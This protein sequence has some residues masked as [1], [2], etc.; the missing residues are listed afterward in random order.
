MLAAAVGRLGARPAA[1]QFGGP[2]QAGD[3]VRR[4]GVARALRA[5]V[6]DG[7]AGFYGGEFGAGLL[8]VGAGEFVADD[9]ATPLADWVEPLSVDVFGHRLWTVPPNSQGYLTL[10]MTA[11]AEQLALPVN[12]DDPTW[13]H[14]TIEAARVASYDRLDVLHEHADGAAL[15]A[16]DRLAR[17]AALVNPDRALELSD[18]FRPGGTIHLTAVDDE[19]CGVSLIQSN[20]ALFGSLLTEPST[21]IFLQNRGLGFSLTAGHPAEYGPGRRPPHTLSPALVTTRANQLHMVLGTQGGDTQPQI[22]LQILARMLHSGQSAG[23]AMDARRW[24]LSSDG[25]FNT[26]D[27]RGRVQV[28]LEVGSPTSWADG[29]SGRGHH[30]VT[31]PL[32]FNFGHAQVIRVMGDVL[33]GASDGRAVSG[34][35]VGC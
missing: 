19:R 32:G 10:A 6:R 4:P 29:L 11:I 22:L 14:L 9:L 16:R 8:A 26:W 13:A 18:H 30:V 1:A 33:E 24:T 20:A 15:L 7:R 31:P 21:G 35:A 27:S 5:V 34:A 17:R 25:G 3:L 2:L 12:P 28:E 23:T